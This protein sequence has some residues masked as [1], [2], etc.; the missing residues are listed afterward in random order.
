MAVLAASDSKPCE[1]DS[2]NSISQPEMSKVTIAPLDYVKVGMVKTPVLITDG[3]SLEDVSGQLRPQHFDLWRDYLSQEDRRSM[4]NV[5]YALVHRFN[6][7]GHVGRQEEESKDLVYRTFLCLRLIRPTRSRYSAIQ[8]KQAGPD[9]IDVFSFTHPS[10]I[11]IYIPDSEVL[12]HFSDADFSNLRRLIGPFLQVAKH[13]PENLRRAIRYYESGYSSVFDPAIQVMVW[14]MGL[15]AVVAT[16]DEIPSRRDLLERINELVAFDRDIYEDSPLTEFEPTPVVQV[17]A[18]IYDLLSLRSRLSHGGW[19]PAA[20][21]HKLTRKSI[22]GRVVSYFEILRETAS[23][24][25]RNAICNRLF[26]ATAA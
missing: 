16:S 20:W 12:N 4:P 24:L 14:T 2:M 13:G 21:E 8:F 9:S 11:P 1:R 26:S 15:E 6:S 25:L 5:R 17:K 19:F 3:V 22:D 7:P 23:F 18:V 10:K